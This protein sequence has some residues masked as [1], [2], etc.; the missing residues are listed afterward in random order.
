[1]LGPVIEMKVP[2]FSSSQYSHEKDLP[3]NTK[4][5]IF[6]GANDLNNHWFNYSPPFQCDPA[7]KS[8]PDQD[9]NNKTDAILVDINNHIISKPKVPI[10]KSIQETFIEYIAPNKLSY[11]E[12]I[13]PGKALQYPFTN[14]DKTFNIKNYKEQKQDNCV[15]GRKAATTVYAN[16][17]NTITEPCKE[18]RRVTYVNTPTYHIS[19]QSVPNISEPHYEFKNK[20]S[21][22]KKQNQCNLQRNI[23]NQNISERAS[24]SFNNENKSYNIHIPK[25]K[26][27]ARFEHE[28]TQ[29]QSLNSSSNK[30]T[31]VNPPL[32][33]NYC[34]QL[35]TDRFISQNT[36]FDKPNEVEN[37]WPQHL[38][39]YSIDKTE[40]FPIH[41]LRDK[42]KQFNYSTDCPDI[43]KKYIQNTNYDTKINTICDNISLKKQE[44]MWPLYD[45]QSKTHITNHSDNIGVSTI[46]DRKNERLSNK[47]LN[48][49]NFMT[50][51]NFPNEFIHQTSRKNNDLDVTY[52]KPNGYIPQLNISQQPL[53]RDTDKSKLSTVQ[54]L[55][56]L[57]TY[58]ADKSHIGGLNNRV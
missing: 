3:S 44:K 20:R 17:S 50:I 46:N 5:R 43:G 7:E 30:K 38:Q 23:L 24:G 34:Q 26:K 49:N 10:E 41:E 42:N 45:N 51:Y 21:I 33:N 15:L 13:I 14:I 22:L 27:V 9:T 40:M 58:N 1:M 6:E 25:F 37:K 11:S 4:P 57:L 18:T 53:I 36:R 28:N 39:S 29:H 55:P 2:T 48:R 54:Q 16:Q 47:P 12:P 19:R 31:N 8:I 56:Y 32:I 52:R 35:S